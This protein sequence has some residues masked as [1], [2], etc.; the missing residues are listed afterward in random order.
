MGSR[1]LRLGT[2]RAILRV[3]LLDDALSETH[4]RRSGRDREFVGRPSAECERNYNTKQLAMNP[5]VSAI[6][7]SNAN[8]S[9]IGGSSGHVEISV[10][11]GQ[12]ESAPTNLC[13]RT[14]DLKGLVNAKPPI[15]LIPN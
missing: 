7:P 5:V 2:R 4:R 11:I 14:S 10:A 6:N 12:V 1:R 3:P 15:R 13:V 9:P 8:D